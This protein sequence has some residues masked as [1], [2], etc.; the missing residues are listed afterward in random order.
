MLALVL[1]ALLAFALPVIKPLVVMVNVVVMMAAVSFVLAPALVVR[2][3][4]PP[5]TPVTNVQTM[6]IVLAGMTVRIRVAIIAVFVL[7]QLMMH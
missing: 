6:L 5:L 3:V 2:P 7:L 1:L 4:I